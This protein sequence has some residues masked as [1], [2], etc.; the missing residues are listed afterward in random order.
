MTIFWGREEI[1][2]GEGNNPYKKGFL[3]NPY[4]KLEET[5]RDVGI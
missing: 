1:R 3:K 4:K 5:S 2:N